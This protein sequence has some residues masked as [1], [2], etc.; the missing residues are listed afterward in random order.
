MMELWASTP[1]EGDEPTMTSSIPWVL[2]SVPP[3]GSEWLWRYGVMRASHLEHFEEFITEYRS[4]CPG[5]LH[6]G[7][8]LTPGKVTWDQYLDMFHA[9]DRAGVCNCSVARTTISNEY[10]YVDV[11]CGYWTT[12]YRY[13]V[14]VDGGGYIQEGIQWTP[15][16][17]KNV[18]FDLLIK[19]CE[20]DNYYAEREA[21]PP[22]GYHVP[23]DDPPE[24]PSIG[25]LASNDGVSDCVWAARKSYSL[26]NTIAGKATAGID[27][28]VTFDLTRRRGCQDPYSNR[29]FVEL[30][31]Y[32]IEG[33]CLVL[34]TYAASG[35]P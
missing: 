2:P 3:E 14:T 26:I 35:S 29:L 16:G 23:D 8:S 22:A 20:F 18:W 11:D 24:S 15:P 25:R 12:V 32:L 27:E 7:I 5:C 33:A 19:G 10:T 4:K 17:V 34:R 6:P 21:W 9:A 1:I 30:D 28:E 31:G 13:T